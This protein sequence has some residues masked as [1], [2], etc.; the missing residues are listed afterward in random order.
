MNPAPLAYPTRT[1]VIVVVV[2]AVAISALVLGYLTTADR[3]GPAAEVTGAGVD[4]ANRVPGGVEALIPRDGAEIL[5]QETIGIDLAPGWTGELLLLPGNGQATTLPEDELE[6]DEL[7][8]IT[9]TPGEG[10]VIERLSGDY[11]LAATIW[12]RVEGREAT[13]K[14]ENWCFS[15][16]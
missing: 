10:K 13:Q 6:R 15:A 5:G 11:C 9:F 7:D 14:T 1:K 16:T 4:T 2:L 3:G 8:R 12:D